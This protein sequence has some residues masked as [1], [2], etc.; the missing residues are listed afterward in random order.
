[1]KVAKLLAL[2]SI[3]LLSGCVVRSYELVKDRVDQDLEGNR[4]FVAGEAPAEEPKDRKTTRTTYVTEVELHSPIKFEK[5]PK[6]IAAEPIRLEEPLSAEPE[7]A[8]ENLDDALIQ[9]NRG[10]ITRGNAPEIVEPE[11]YEKYTVKKRDTLQKISKYFYGTTKDWVKIYSANKDKLKGPD[12]I[13]VGQVLNIP[14]KG[15]KD[16]QENLK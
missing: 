3:F 14:L 9:G 13:Y 16:S 15:L 12:K 4:G 1:M 11:A 10:Y 8:G 7:Y 6:R 2:L 5:G